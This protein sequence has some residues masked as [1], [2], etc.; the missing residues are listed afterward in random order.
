MFQKFE[1]KVSGQGK[2]KNLP[3]AEKVVGSNFEMGASTVF[4]LALSE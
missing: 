4:A 1:K 3:S 2:L